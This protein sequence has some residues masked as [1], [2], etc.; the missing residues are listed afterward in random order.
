M[1]DRAYMNELA[2]NE[3]GKYLYCLNRAKN[4]MEHNDPH[5]TAHW[6]DVAHMALKQSADYRTRRK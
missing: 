2:D 3:Y 4:S 5:G 1:K 6:L